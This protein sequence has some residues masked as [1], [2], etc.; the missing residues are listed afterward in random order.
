MLVTGDFNAPPRAPN[1]LL[2]E[3]AG[4][5]SSDEL[6]GDSPGAS[7]Y[8]FYGIRL[9]SL[10]DVLVNA[11]WRVE[12][13]QVLDVKPGNTFPS[14]HFGVMADLMLGSDSMNAVP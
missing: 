7:T 12:A 2:F 5:M 6:I 4:L 14:D 10:D 3:E 1:R 8:Q 9:K 13:R 11:G